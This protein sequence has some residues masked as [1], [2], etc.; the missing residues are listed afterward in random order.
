MNRY[1]YLTAMPRIFILSILMFLFSCDSNK[2]LA[3]VTNLDIEKYAGTW[4][5]IAKL[6]NSFERGLTCVKAKYT[7]L[8]NGKIEVINS[9]KKLSDGTWKEITGKAKVPDKAYPGRLKV[10]FFWPFAGDYYVIDLADD[11]SYSLVGNPGRDYLW[12]LSRT[13]Q[14]PEVIYTQLLEKA[15]SHGFPVDKVEKMDQ[16]CEM[17]KEE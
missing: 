15:K 9:G 1:P 7:P 11:Y 12:I 8:A 16:S 3:T 17:P 5:E 14:I 10:T 4:Y 2:D 13:P 6:P